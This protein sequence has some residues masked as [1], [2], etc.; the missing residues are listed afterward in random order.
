PA[1]GTPTETRDAILLA[2]RASSQADH[3]TLAAAFARRGLGS[4]A[5]SMPRDS[6]VFTG[7]V[8][9]L[10]VHANV[11]AEAPVLA[12]FSS[13]DRD[14]VV[15]AGE[16][17]RIVLAISNRGGKSL[18]G[19]TAALT[20]TTP[21]VSVTS[22]PIVLDL[23]SYEATAIAFDFVLDPTIT[24]PVD[25]AFELSIRGGDSCQD[26]LTIAIPARLNVDDVVSSSATDSFDAGS[27]PWQSTF[28]AI[29][30]LHR[31]TALDGSW[32]GVAPAV[33][34]DGSLESPPLT[35]G[36]GPLTL[37]FTHRYSFETTNGSVFDG[38]VIEYSLDGSTWID[39]MT[40][41][42][43]IPYGATPLAGVGNA[44]AGRVG[45]T[46]NS[47]GYPATETLTLDFGTQL[48]DQMF[49]IRFRLATDNTNASAGW[50]VDDVVFTGIV[51]TPFPVQIADATACSDA[52]PTDGGSEPPVVDG[53][54]CGTGTPTSGLLALL[55]LVALRRRER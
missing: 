48:A 24:E 19:A 51:G 16:R 38:G 18:A 40:L 44:L 2:A 42:P 30:K 20:T 47:P 25:G 9:S 11:I 35:A 12:A 21:G 23:D 36:S 27:S 22:S 43:A 55:V 26:P 17:G 54:C 39:V 3:D 31:E 46:G 5:V 8:E 15:D 45:F 49:K 32:R 50:D 14:D 7:V 37:S 4:C 33:F 6:L 41:V 13:C 34:S 53:G 1:D 28:V 10:E 29:W 52:P